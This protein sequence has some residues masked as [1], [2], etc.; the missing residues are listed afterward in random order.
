MKID[1]GQIGDQELEIIK[2]ATRNRETME[3]F[4]NTLT[5]DIEE[6][7]QRVLTTFLKE[8]DQTHLFNCLSYCTL[9]L[10]ANAN[11]ANAKRVYF[12]EQKLNIDNEKDY[13]S[14]MENFRA[15]LTGNKIHYMTELET[16]LLEINLRL[17]NEGII[18]VRVS[19]NTQITATE[20][21]RIQEKIEMA[22]KYK[23]MEEAL[24]YID[25][26]EGSGLGLIIIVLMLKELGL[27]ETH[28][29]FDTNEN[30]TIASIEIPIDTF[31][32]I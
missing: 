10:L 25:Q 20:Y 16:S 30:E 28:L 7:F 4:S 6:N 1:I 32:E 2:T 12:K 22:K 19:N 23:S 17:S 5:R 8:C 11:K 3:F 9:E 18:T 15:A 31:A 13:S 26:T 14:G 27:D 21:S 29:H 24:S